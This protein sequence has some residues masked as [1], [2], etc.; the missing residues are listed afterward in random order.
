MALS[1]HKQI[2]TELLE[3]DGLLIMGKGLGIHKVFK[4]FVK[5]YCDPNCLV[6]LLNVSAHEQEHLLEELRM[7]GIKCMPKTIN[8][9]ISAADR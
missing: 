9:D 5:L 2:F 1:F 7:E 6:F 8:T 4:N 3:E